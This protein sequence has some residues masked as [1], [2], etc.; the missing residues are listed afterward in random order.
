MQVLQHDAEERPWGRQSPTS[1]VIGAFDGVVLNC[2]VLELG[3]KRGK[4]AVCLRVYFT[5]DPTNR[6]CLPPK[7]WRRYRPPALC[8]QHFSCPSGAHACPSLC[9]L[10]EPDATAGPEQNHETAQSRCQ[11]RHPSSMSSQIQDSKTSL[12]VQYAPD[13]HPDP[14]AEGV[15]VSSSSLRHPLPYLVWG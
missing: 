2:V 1:R 5:L 7:P 15:W 10:T 9:H 11:A 8:M 4:D 12:S 6:F 14:R 3:K 13:K